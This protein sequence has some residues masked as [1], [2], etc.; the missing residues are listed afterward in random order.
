MN[1]ECA[2]KKRTPL[3]LGVVDLRALAVTEP[4]GEGRTG[5]TEK[6]QSIFSE[7]RMNMNRVNYKTSSPGWSL[8]SELVSA[9]VR[10][11]RGLVRL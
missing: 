1:A 4:A 6:G 7:T 9:G 11:L 8:S 3:G 10:K 2:D 5:K